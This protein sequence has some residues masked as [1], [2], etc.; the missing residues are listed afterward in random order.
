LSEKQYAPEWAIRI[1]SSGTMPASQ[2]LPHES[3]WRTHPPAQQLA[4][5][6][7]LDKVGWVQSVIISARSGKVLDGHM[8][9][10]AALT[11]GEETPVPYIE[12]DL[13]EEE[14]RL[15]LTTIDPISA[16][17]I[18]DE[19][20][21]KNLLIETQ[22]ENNDMLDVLGLIAQ[23]T[24]IDLSALTSPQPPL[25]P[26]VSPE[27]TPQ[28]PDTPDYS[29]CQGCATCPHWAAAKANAP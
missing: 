22:R 16:M 23:T 19:D 25:S 24:Q 11:H 13:T 14:E 26:S 12:V 27:L 9:V 4:L 21:Y 29:D 20:A 18:T 1:V 5:K 17:A 10:E 8:R 28:K 3:N 2:F 6:A 15:V 7:V